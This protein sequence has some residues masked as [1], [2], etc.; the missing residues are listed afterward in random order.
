MRRFCISGAFY[1]LSMLIVPATSDRWS[2]LE[3]LFGSNGASG[4]CWCMWW[5]QGNKEHAASKGEGNRLK[6]KAL[7][8]R[9]GTA[10]GLLA[11]SADE[12]GEL[13]AVGWVA[14]APRAEYPR[15]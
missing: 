8:E 13:Q 3:R 15:D 10:P 9:K 11:Y 2:D 1:N 12:T 6:L 14:V 5:R 7:V 4:G